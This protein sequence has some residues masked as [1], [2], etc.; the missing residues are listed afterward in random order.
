MKLLLFFSLFLL[1]SLELH[2]QIIT[3]KVVDAASN[4]LLEYVSIGIVKTPIGTITNES[5]KFNLEF[6]KQSP[7]AIVRFSMIG[8]KAQTFSIEELSDKENVIKLKQEA[9]QINEIVVKANNKLKKVG[10]TNRTISGGFC[11]WAG[12]RRGKGHEIGLKIDLGTSFVKLQSLHIRV[13]KQSY[14]SSLFR[15]HI[16]NIKD[17]LPHKELLKQN[18]LITI[19]ESSG[20]VEIDLSKYNIVLKGEIALTLEW[21]KVLGINKNNLIR[22]NDSNQKSANV[23][24]SGKNKE[25]CRYKKWGAE[26]KWSKN[27]SPMPSIYLTVLE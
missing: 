20:W 24:F 3:G 19:T 14:D 10:T 9:I 17:D 5:G 7:K 11:G 16:R 23:L 4:D 25:G 8:Y 1:L 6:K 12:N 22:V 15:L 27:N 13:H 18:I 2:S 26:D 21:L